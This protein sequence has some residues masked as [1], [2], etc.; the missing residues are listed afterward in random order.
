[1]TEQK[2]ITAPVVELIDVRD[3]MPPNG[4]K[5][6]A[7]GLGGV[8]AQTV[9]T[10]DAHEFFIAWAPYPKIPASVKARLQ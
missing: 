9:W 5:V 4:A 8:L 10:R 1:M 2:H 6:L 3:Q 7:L